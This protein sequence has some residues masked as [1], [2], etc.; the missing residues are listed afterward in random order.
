MFSLIPTVLTETH[1]EVS[2]QPEAFVT[3]TANDPLAVAVNVCEVSPAIAAPEVQL[4][5]W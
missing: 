1:D 3:I 4:I 5:H 2:E